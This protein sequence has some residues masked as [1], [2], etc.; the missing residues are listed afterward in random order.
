M[1]HHLLSFGRGVSDYF[2]QYCCVPLTKQ[3]KS[4]CNS[5]YTVIHVELHL[6]PGGVYWLFK[7]TLCHRPSGLDHAM[8]ITLKVLRNVKLF[9]EFYL[10]IS[11]PAF[12]CM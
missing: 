6:D 9:C 12:L 3:F 7:V 8:E 10:L 2:K 1:F 5:S 11:H 4:C